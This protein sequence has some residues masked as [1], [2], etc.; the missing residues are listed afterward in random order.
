MGYSPWSHKELDTT[1]QL[2]LPL[3]LSTWFVETAASPSWHGC[4]WLRRRRAWVPLL[5]QGHQGHWQNRLGWA[6]A[7]ER[8]MKYS[9]THW[10][11]HLQGLEE[12]S[13]NGERLPNKKMEQMT[14]ILK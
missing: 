11:T 13:V 9:L 4:Q 5:L 7:D 14:K 6:C 8:M 1:E 10:E 12:I 3:L 2:I